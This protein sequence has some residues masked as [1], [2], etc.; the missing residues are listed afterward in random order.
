MWWKSEKYKIKRRTKE[1]NNKKAGNEDKTDILKSYY[2]WI[3]QSV[4]NSK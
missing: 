2:A 1:R 4:I 3:F